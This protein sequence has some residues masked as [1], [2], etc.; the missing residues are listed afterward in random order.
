MYDK[1]DF[2]CEEKGIKPATLCKECGIN[3]STL[4]E[5]KHGRTKSLSAQTLSKISQYF[6][7]S[8]DFFNE[9][10]FTETQK[11]ELFE[12]RKLLFDMSKRA[13]AE[14]LDS[15][16]NMIKTIIPNDDAE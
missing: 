4:S 7:V 15:F 11:D 3:K 5:L 6:G 10:D 8:L 9:D 14:Q 13:T 1:I 2:L 16:I 12:K